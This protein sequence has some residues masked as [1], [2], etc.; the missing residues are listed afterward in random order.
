MCRHLNICIFIYIHTDLEVLGEK[1]PSIDDSNEVSKKR[2]IRRERRLHMISCNDVLSPPFWVLP[3]VHSPQYLAHLWELAEEADDGD[4][5]VPLEFDTEWESAEAL[6]DSDNETGHEYDEYV[7]RNRENGKKKGIQLKKKINIDIVEDLLGV[8]SVDFLNDLLSPGEGD[9]TV[10]RAL[11]GLD[12][13]EMK[14]K[15]GLSILGS[16]RD[17]AVT[18]DRRGKGDV[19]GGEEDGEDPGEGRFG[20]GDQ[21]STLYG[22]GIVVRKQIENKNIFEIQLLWGYGYFHDSNVKLIKKKI[23]FYESS[24][25]VK[26][27]VSVTINQS[28]NIN[29]VRMKK[30]NEDDWRVK[31]DEENALNGSIKQKKSKHQISGDEVRGFLTSTKVG[32]YFEL[33][34]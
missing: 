25:E 3:L 1:D 17:T 33:L 19:K 11:Q 10:A 13:E 9:F 16:S 32:Y 20:R 5:Y 26:D 31:K 2:V 6:P 29:R 24:S 21:V 22:N 18:R 30:E 4:L 23:R 28:N 12:V 27:K 14:R 15:K 7:R 8:E 34:G